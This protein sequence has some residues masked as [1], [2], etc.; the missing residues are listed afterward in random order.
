MVR[1]DLSGSEVAGME[2]LADGLR[3]RLSAAAVSQWR[4]DETSPP[5]CGHVA[6]VELILAGL[7][8]LVNPRDGMGRIADARLLLDGQ[9][10]VLTLPMT[11]KGD[12]R[13]ELA[14][15]NRETLLVHAQSLNLR[16]PENPQFNE[17]FAC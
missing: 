13:L 6:G 7:T 9:V 8:G 14:F 4:V 12:I 5:L 17:S 3:I 2:V 16:L 15:A 11:L 10:Q 1:F